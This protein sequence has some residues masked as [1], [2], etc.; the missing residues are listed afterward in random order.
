LLA[1]AL[2]TAIAG[3]ASSASAATSAR[4]KPPATCPTGTWHKLPITVTRHVHVPPTPVI[5]TVRT[6]PHRDCGYDRIV[7]VIAGKHPGYTIR[8]VAHV[9]ADP[10]G[11]TITLPGKR[12]VLITLRPAQGTLPTKVQVVKYP[13]LRSWV[14][15]GDFEGVVSIGIG[16]RSRTSV[17]VG[18]LKGRLY[19]DF[20]E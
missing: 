8:Y 3:V 18:E 12:F 16:L 9:I 5:K 2:A 11:K 15:A 1:A 7:F 19:V 17:R 20:K 10:S 13:M 14:L 6:A 4:A